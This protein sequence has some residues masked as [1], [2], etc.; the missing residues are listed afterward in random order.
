M[1]AGNAGLFT[2]EGTR[3]YIVGRRT[4]A[5][6]DPG[7]D[8]GSHVRAVVSRA[9]T[10][11]RVVVVLTHGHADHAGAASR[12]AAE[13][14][15]EVL[16]PTGVEQVGRVLDDGDA[17]ETDEGALVAVHT[18]GHTREHLCFHWPRRSAVFVGDL[19]LGRGDTTWVA[20]YPGCVADYLESLERLRSLEPTVLYPAHGPPLTDPAE[21]LDR[22]ERHR[23]ERIAQV[24]EA[25]RAH[26]E[27][28][29]DGLVDAVY[30]DAVPSSMRPAA[31]RSLEAILHHLD[32]SGR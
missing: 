21:A 1:Q 17:V 6:I 3:S 4:A 18:P 32:H 15:A 24:R 2:L 27:A 25:R 11:E 14:G 7:P 28:D 23:T 13:L 20:E 9:A 19:L 5:I 10:A 31:L 8:V 26:P 30:G 12:V 29:A 22:F 16:G